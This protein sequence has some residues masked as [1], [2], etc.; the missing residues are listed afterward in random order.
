MSFLQRDKRKSDDD[1]VMLM[2]GGHETISIPL[3]HSIGDNA[4]YITQSHDAVYDDIW[5]FGIYLAQSIV[6]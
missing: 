3:V 5:G 1:V 6:I 2:D 4:S